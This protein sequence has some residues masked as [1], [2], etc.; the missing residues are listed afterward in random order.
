MLF[1]A[2]VLSLHNCFFVCVKNG[3]RRLK[4]LVASSLLLQVCCLLNDAH[5]R[6]S[7]QGR[8]FRCLRKTE[9]SIA[10]LVNELMSEKVLMYLLT[11]VYD[12]SMLVLSENV[13]ICSTASVTFGQKSFS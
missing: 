9:V 2:V 13:H 6:C 11:K 12:I 4:G 10:E 7:V 8:F 3:F 1:L 5:S